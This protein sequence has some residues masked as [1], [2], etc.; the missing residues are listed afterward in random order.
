MV[1]RRLNRWE[2]E[3]DGTAIVVCN[4]LSKPERADSVRLEAARI[5]NAATIRSTAVRDAELDQAR[6]KAAGF[7]DAEINAYLDTVRSVIDSTYK[8]NRR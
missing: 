2:G 7:T 1:I 6:L 3:D 5:R 4:D 8:A